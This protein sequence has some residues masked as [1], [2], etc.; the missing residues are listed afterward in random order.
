[1]KVKMQC[2]AIM[3]VILT[4]SLKLPIT[5]LI[6]LIKLYIYTIVHIINLF[7]IYKFI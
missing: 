7:L 1:M 4:Y 2:V 6:I 3:I 5:N